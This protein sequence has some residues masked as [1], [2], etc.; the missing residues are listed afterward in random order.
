[1]V[2]YEHF[3]ELSEQ[4]GVGNLLW[5]DLETLASDVFLKENENEM[6]IGKPEHSAAAENLLTILQIS[7][8]LDPANFQ[9][10]KREGFE[11]INDYMNTELAL[12]VVDRWKHGTKWE[13]STIY[14]FIHENFNRESK[15]T[16]KES[17][18]NTY[19]DFK[20]SDEE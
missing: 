12:A 1:L 15:Y 5:Y 10:Y 3:I 8:D 13:R 9:N 18:V 20:F 7:I 2:R 17:E 19:C 14:R 6:Q 11:T 16:L 4:V